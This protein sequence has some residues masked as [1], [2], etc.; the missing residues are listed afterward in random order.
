MSGITREINDF[1]NNHWEM[2]FSN[3]PNFTGR[4]DLPL[5]IFSGKVK[6]FNVPDCS[7]PM[8]STVLG[9]AIAF[10]PA[11][12]GDRHY[13]TINI[14]F[15]IDE[16]AYNWYA[17]YSWMYNTLHG[18][19]ERTNLKGEPCVHE[20]CIDAIELHMLNNEHEPVSKILFKRC[21]LNNLSGLRLTYTASE[22]GTI[23]ATFQVEELD[24]KLM[25][26]DDE[27]ENQNA[28]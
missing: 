25:D 17:L 21:H 12:T 26:E 16:R 6:D 3:F 28:M 4:K 13:G 15:S 22:I 1:N 5:E 2:H 10:H 23:I 14:E 20:N 8:L 18:K 7:I 27:T 24:F 11:T 19:A 9:H